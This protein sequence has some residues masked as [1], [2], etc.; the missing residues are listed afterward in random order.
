[1]FCLSSSSA[2]TFSWFYGFILYVYRAQAHAVCS[3]R[4]AV[5]FYMD[6]DRFKASA[7]YFH[8]KNSLEISLYKRT[9][10][11][12]SKDLTWSQI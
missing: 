10:K 3:L 11:K 2:H 12:A 8:I 9:F 1:M 6:S 4:E 5:S 7:G